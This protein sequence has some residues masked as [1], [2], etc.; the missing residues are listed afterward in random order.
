MAKVETR[1]QLHLTV[2][3]INALNKARDVLL[4]IEEEDTNGEVFCQAD[5]Y[6]TEWCWITAFL[7]N[8][9]KFSEVEVD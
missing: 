3:E 9:V 4:E 8:L 1:L 2:E 5:N 7:D 6:E